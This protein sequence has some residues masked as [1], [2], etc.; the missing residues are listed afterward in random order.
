MSVHYPKVRVRVPEKGEAI[1]T[2][3]EVDGQMWP[4]TRFAF[5]T[6]E[7]LSG[8][9]KVRMEFHAGIDFE[10]D[11]PLVLTSAGPIR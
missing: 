8:L 2:T 4:V 5:D 3:V 1:L 11:V 10:S 7:S 9:V 6:G